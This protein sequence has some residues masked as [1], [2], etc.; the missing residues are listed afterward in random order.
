[1]TKQE[2][3][4]K[5]FFL[6]NLKYI[7]IDDGWI[8]LVD[9]MCQQINNKNPPPQFQIKQIKQKFGYLRVYTNMFVDGVENIIQQ[10]EIQSTNVCEICGKSGKLIKRNYIRTLC[11]EHVGDK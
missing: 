5:Y 8:D 3:K 11:Q 10:F 1:M 2:L 4:E 7:E 6:T 9:E